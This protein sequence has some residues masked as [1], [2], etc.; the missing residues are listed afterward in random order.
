MLGFMEIIEEI[1]GA[2]GM[3]DDYEKSSDFYLKV[4]GNL[5]GDLEIRSYYPGERRR[6]SVL[7]RKVDIAGKM[8]A[9]EV[10]VTT[11]G[12]PIAIRREGCWKQV[13]YLDDDGGLAFLPGPL[14]EV[15]KYLETWAGRIREQ[16]Y[17]EEATRQNDSVRQISL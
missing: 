16:G 17:V 6:V 2:A 15:L 14:K 1:V 13:A 12:Q 8:V 3:S 9:I 11:G 5:C 10:E 4:Q 7:Q